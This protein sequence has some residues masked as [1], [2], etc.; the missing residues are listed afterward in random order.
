[1]V[2]QGEGIGPQD[3]ASRVENQNIGCLFLPFEMDI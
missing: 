1:M 3:W 2:V